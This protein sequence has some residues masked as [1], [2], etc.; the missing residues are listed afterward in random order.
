MFSGFR[1]L[2]LKT[3]VIPV[4][5]P[6]FRLGLGIKVHEGALRD[7]ASPVHNVK[8]VEV[9]EGAGYLSSIEP[10]SGLQED[11]LSLEMIEQLE[12]RKKTTCVQR[13]QL[14]T[15]V[16]TTSGQHRHVNLPLHHSRSPGQSRACQ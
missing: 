11:P 7:Q 16:L 2:Y 13:Q 4:V 15:D 3:T 10:G 8:G 6:V 9:A 5:L 12:R 1:S 14:N